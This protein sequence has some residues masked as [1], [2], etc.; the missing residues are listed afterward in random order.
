M[1]IRK[2]FIDEKKVIETIS[3]QYRAGSGA[4]FMFGAGTSRSCGIKTIKELM[5]NGNGLNG[6]LFEQY[7]EWMSEM[8]RSEQSETIRGVIYPAK[9]TVTDRWVSNYCYLTLT[10]I[11]KKYVKSTRIL[12]TTNFDPILFHTLVQNNI[13]P[14]LIRHG[15]EVKTM[16]GMNT[17]DFPSIMYLHGLWQNHEIMNTEEDFADVRESWTYPLKEIK[18]KNHIIILGYQGWPTDVFMSSLNNDKGHGGNEEKHIYW[19]FHQNEIEQAKR[20]L[21]NLSNKI[22][23][24]HFVKI[25]GADEFML[26]LGV[27][28]HLKDI[29][30]LSCLSSVMNAYKPAISWTFDNRTT[31]DCSFVDSNFPLTIRFETGD[32]PDPGDNFAGIVIPPIG[33]TFDA[34]IFKKIKIV[35]TFELITN[36][37]IW[38]KFLIKLGIMKGPRFEL[39]LGSQNK[40]YIRYVDLD[41][42]T[43]KGKKNTCTQILTNYEDVELSELTKVIIAT[44]SAQIGTKGVLTLEI[45]EI[46]FE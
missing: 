38:V 39:K 10:K 22:E 5:A 44:N 3:K 20:V 29:E 9:S 4:V 36:R 16:D 21:G 14:K 46:S 37:S 17:I 7:L 19:C 28:L 11:W 43:N 35:F 34:S 41:T 45:F 1:N 24:L 40:E 30:L 18:S 42:K 31:I 12:L 13:E 32:K 15:E 33:E 2:F 25:E 26:K 6:D 8:T 23:N 27:R